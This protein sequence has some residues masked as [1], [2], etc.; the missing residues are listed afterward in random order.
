MLD[1]DLSADAGLLAAGAAEAARLV[2]LRLAERLAGGSVAAGGGFEPGMVL[3]WA[4]GWQGR[5]EESQAVL[6][7]L[8][9]TETDDTQRATLAVA[10][11]GSLYWPLGKPDLAE[12][13]LTE[14]QQAL[15]DEQLAL[16]LTALQTTFHAWQ[17]RHE[18]A[19]RTG[20]AVFAAKDVPPGAVLLAS[21]GLVLS[22]GARGQLAQIEPVTARAYAAAGES[23][24]A[25][26]V[27]PC[28]AARHLVALRLAGE[29][30]KC[31][32]LAADL[33]A[34]YSRAP[35]IQPQLGAAWLGHSALSAGRVSTAAGLL[36][37]ATAGIPFAPN[38]EHGNTLLWLAE[39]F[40]KLGAAPP[41]RAALA[42]WVDQRL[43]GM[44]HLDPEVLL[45]Q[46][47]IAAAEGAVSEAIRLARDAATHAASLSQSAHEV[48]AL[49]T[50]TCFGDRDTV[51]R[52][53]ELATQ[54][55]GPRAAAAAA[56]AAA[57]AADDG[58]GLHTASLRLEQMGDMLAAADTA[59]QAATVH[60][61]HGH[62]AEQASATA[63]AR[64]LA[65]A[66]GG[67]RTPA[68]TALTQP[69]PLTD[70][71]REIVTLAATGMT[72]R[73]IADR[74]VVSVRTV[75]GHLYR[76]AAKP[77]TSDRTQLAAL[78]HTD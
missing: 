9:G 48:L 59:A 14:A 7:T 53:T 23:F 30:R 65:T 41:A 49:H 75:E 78:L 13:L 18:Q 20:Y 26:Q 33:D 42:D 5:G 22:L 70:R 54:V 3:V 40:A 73:L 1:S 39:A 56:Q 55:D 27:A 32:R 67:A 62:R 19:E 76:A 66:C 38:P 61:R 29:L 72:N 35:G 11:A 44:A 60:A 74:L 24:D 69:L 4:L 57:L 52:L 58:P 71:E 45:V 47:W 17:T 50:A 68:L 15:A 51:A 34:R 31:E 37:H 12:A 2:D 36:R 10:R 21:Y 77:G 64:H 8:V 28:V 46:A 16:P 6:A 43:P 25:A 63:R